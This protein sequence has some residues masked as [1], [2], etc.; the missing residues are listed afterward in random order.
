MR[1]LILNTVASV[2][3]A[4]TL[5][6]PAPAGAAEGE[7]ER[8]LDHLARLDEVRVSPLGEHLLVQ[9]LDGPLSR[10][11]ARPDLPLDLG[12]GERSEVRVGSDPVEAALPPQPG[13]ES[14]GAGGIMVVVFA[15]TM[16]FTRPGI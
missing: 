1:H 7:L 2:L 5:S 6:G 3:L 4:A 12:P 16:A 10:A 15:L 8:A 11:P 9:P 13:V 14:G